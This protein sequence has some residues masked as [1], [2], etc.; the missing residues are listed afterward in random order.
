MQISRA[1]LYELVW[2]SPLSKTAPRFG[3][4][5]TALAAV[6]KKRSIP[7]PG[8]LY[9]TMKSMGRSVEVSRCRQ[10]VRRSGCGFPKVV[11]LV[12]PR[13]W[14]SVAFGRRTTFSA[15]VRCHSQG[16]GPQGRDILRSERRRGPERAAPV[17]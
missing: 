4:S 13:S 15:T 10:L 8:S 11:P 12:R 3:I 14:I 1:E 7:Y 17:L 16:N 9:W 5:A 2:K 6:C